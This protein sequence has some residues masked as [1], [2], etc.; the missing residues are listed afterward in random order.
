MTH[1]T[2]GL[3]RVG[4]IPAEMWSRTNLIFKKIYFLSLKN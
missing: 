4:S 1:S 2:R 3:A